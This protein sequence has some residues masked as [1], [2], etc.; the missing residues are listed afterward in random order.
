MDRTAKGRPATA[1]RTRS[2]A[3]VGL[4][5]A[6]LAVSAWVTVPF[7]P[8]P[9]TLQTFA[10]VFAVLAL[11]P[12]EAVASIA[13]YLALGAVGLPVF[14]GMR[15]G[16]GVLAGPTGG[17][18]WGFLLGVALAALLHAVPKRP[19][20]AVDFAAGA[21][22]VGACYVCGWAQYM[23]VMG[24]GPLEALLV[25]V[26]PFVIIDVVKIGAAVGVANAV[27]RAAG[28]APRPAS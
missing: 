8:V 20:A 27:A 26:A 28:R 24:A 12:K 14:S 13:G 11:S 5:V 23:T 1:S 17:F 16:L 25:T 7:G 2:I 4:T 15:G 10:V 22:A 9:F 18:L 3:Y 6:V 19:S 21:V